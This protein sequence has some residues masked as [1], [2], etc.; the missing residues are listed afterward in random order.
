MSEPTSPKPPAKSGPKPKRAI[1]LPPGLA[2]R[3]AATDAL[4]AVLD[5]RRPLEEAL[6]AVPGYDALEARDRAFARLLVATATRRLGQ[7]DAMIK[8]CLERAV[9]RAGRMAEHILRI[10]TAQLM[11][12]G[13]PAHA[14]VSAAVDHAEA[15]K[16]T[17]Y[18]KLINAVLRRIAREGEELRDAQDAAKLNTPDWLWRSWTGAYGEATARAIADA[19]LAEP[20]LDITLMPGEPAKQWA[21]RLE[22]H[23]L[24]TGALRRAADLSG[25]IGDLPGYDEGRWWVQDAAAALPAKLLLTALAKTKAAQVA[26]LCAAPGGKTAQLAAVLNKSAGA[27]VVALDVN[28]TRLGRLRQNLERLH[29]T[30][31]TLQADAGDWKPEQALDGVLLDAPCS[32]TGTIRRHPDIARSKRADDVAKLGPVQE[33][34]LANAVAMLKPG[35]VLVYAVC[36]LEAEEGPK[37]IGA[38]LDAN[39]K[40][41]RLP[42]SPAEVGGLDVLIT[43]K[44]DLRSLP[45]QAALPA[46]PA[47]GGFDGF[48]AAR[49]RR[50]G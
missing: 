14:A 28:A 26:D 43:K 13:T 16:L 15:M 5:K 33:R 17:A 49:L 24:P 20:P 12:L 21:E 11:F 23:V 35:G 40:L 19:H 34:L 10:G 30:A 3:A 8:H 36:S 9:P 45:S 7:I 4:A 18:K 32:A 2:A 48:Y 38:L 47:L 22:A 44:G 39:P 25:A 42:V 46:K 31:E 37:R 1:K 50:I 41:E 27:R 6:A 29:L